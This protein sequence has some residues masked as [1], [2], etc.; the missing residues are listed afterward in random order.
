MKKYKVYKINNKYE[1]VNVY[2]KTIVSCT[3][4]KTANE[5]ARLL[6]N[7]TPV[8]NDDV[9]IL[10]RMSELNSIEEHRPVNDNSLLDS[11]IARTTRELLGKGGR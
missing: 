4:E 3:N 9:D 8:T 5:V 6:E 10:E 1:I 2:G 7:D 11:R